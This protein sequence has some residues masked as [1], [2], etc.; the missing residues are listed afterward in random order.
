MKKIANK[1]CKKNIFQKINFHRFSGEKVANYSPKWAGNWQLL[2]MKLHR[3]G[4][5][6]SAG[7]VE[8]PFFF[9]K[10]ST[11]PLFLT[12]LDFF[13]QNRPFNRLRSKNLQNGPIRRGIFFLSDTA[14]DFFTLKKSFRVG[15]W[16]KVRYG[17]TFLDENFFK[18]SKMIYYFFNKL[19]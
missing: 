15:L 17:W 3:L 19:C 11:G 16:L 10:T 7:T 13:D 12:F 1:Y 9:S 6:G 14:R 4:G 18:K 5:T 2:V 8:K